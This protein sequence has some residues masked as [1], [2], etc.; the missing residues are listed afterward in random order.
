MTITV[1]WWHTWKQKGI[2]LLKTKIFISLCKYDECKYSDRFWLADRTSLF[3]QYTI[4]LSSVYKLLWKHWNYK[5]PARYILSSVWVRLS[6]FSPLSTIQY[7]GLYVFIFTHF[8]HFNDLKSQQRSPSRAMNSGYR[9]IWYDI[10]YNTYF[11]CVNYNVKKVIWNGIMTRRLIF[12]E[13]Q[14]IHTYVK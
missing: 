14:V 11:L 12:R 9:E 5:M 13:A 7:V 8:T 1:S 4:S 2:Y 10:S 6:I 3:V